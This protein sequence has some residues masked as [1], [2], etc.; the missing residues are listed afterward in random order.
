MSSSCVQFYLIPELII[1]VLFE[2]KEIIL[3]D[4]FSH[5]FI[6]E[7]SVKFKISLFCRDPL[8]WVEGQRVEQYW[9]ISGDLYIS[10]Y[11]SVEV[12]LLRGGL[13]LK[14]IGFVFCQAG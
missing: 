2:I 6:D 1:K 9:N 4:I 13:V 7:W 14:T 8:F 11:V 12:V 3:V 10:R 5:E